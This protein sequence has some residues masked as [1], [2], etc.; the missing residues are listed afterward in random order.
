[1]YL[2]L[3]C[4]IIRK[5]SITFPYIFQYHF[6]ILL[7]LSVKVSKSRI[8]HIGNILIFLEFS[9]SK[10]IQLSKTG[11]YMLCNVPVFRHPFKPGPC[12]IANLHTFKLPYCTVKF[13]T[14]NIQF[15]QIRD[16]S[17]S[18]TSLFFQ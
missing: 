1:M 12:T 15:E 2:S 10:F 8:N 9:N 13:H 6:I 7:N 17:F 11:N 3:T 5:F 18:F 4:V 14:H 16:S